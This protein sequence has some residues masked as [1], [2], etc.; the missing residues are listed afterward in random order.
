MQEFRT[1]AQT[2]V[3]TIR[4]VSPEHLNPNQI[5]FGGYL[6]CWVDEIAFACAR[7]FSGRNTCVTVNIDSISFRTPIKMN[8][9]ILLTAQVVDAG[10]SSM[11][12]EV[13]VAKEDPATGQTDQTNSAYLTFVCLDEKG[14]PTSVPLLE[15]QTDEEKRKRREAQLRKKVRKRFQRFLERS[16]NRTSDIAAVKR[17][18]RFERAIAELRSHLPRKTLI[19]EIHQRLSRLEKF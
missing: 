13:L 12:I 8:E 10:R 2:T 14:K 3:S 16:L 4:I 9:Q 19:S 15:C 18:D 6:M 7:K 1:P 11:E 5:L 17:P